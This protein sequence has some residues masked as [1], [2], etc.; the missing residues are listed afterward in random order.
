MPCIL[1]YNAR[2]ISKTISSH[3]SGRAQLPDVLKF[4]VD[5]ESNTYKSWGVTSCVLCPPNM[6]LPTKQKTYEHILKRTRTQEMCQQTKK[7]SQNTKPL[8]QK[9][10]KESLYNFDKSS[11]F[12]TKSNNFIYIFKF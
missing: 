10:F 7:F 11:S 3:V 6:Y 8:I 1:H 12:W 9:N 4:I 2:K 5:K